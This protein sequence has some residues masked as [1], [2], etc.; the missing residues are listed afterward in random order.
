[1]R[2]SL[3]LETVDIRR[4]SPRTLVRLEPTLSVAL[5]YETGLFGTELRAAIGKTFS[6]M[7]LLNRSRSSEFGTCADLSNQ[8]SSFDGAY[9]AS[10]YF[11]A[12]SAGTS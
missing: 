8:I 9:G 6:T 5:A 10:K 12:R 11:S 2:P 3:A 4:D 7:V 1:L